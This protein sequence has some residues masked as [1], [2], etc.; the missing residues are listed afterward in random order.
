MKKKMLA[1]LPIF[2]ATATVMPFAAKSVSAVEAQA[3][4]KTERLIAPQTYEEY[5]PLTSPTDVAASENYTAIAD[6]NAIYIYDRQENEY[7]KF[8]HGEENAP[9][10]TVTKLQFDEYGTL[11]FLDSSVSTNFYALNVETGAEKKIDLA[12]GTFTVHGDDL[13]FTNAQED[14]YTLS[15]ASEALSP[16]A[17]RWNNVST[18]SFWN[19]EL[20][21]VRA[22]NYLM[23]IDPKSQA[24]PDPSK[25]TFAIFSKQINH[26]AISDGVLGC[27]NAAG[28]FV[29]YPLSQISDDDMLFKSKA[30]DFSA[31]ST[32]GNYFYT[33]ASSDATV[34]QYST[35]TNAFTDFEISASSDSDHRFSEANDVCLVGDKLFIA[36][37]GNERVSVYNRKTQSFEKAIN[38]ALSPLFLSADEKTL[39]IAS[40]EKAILYSLE[41]ATYGEQ[42]GQFSTFNGKI[43]GTAS[44]YGTYY[45]ISENNYAYTLQASEET[46]A[47]LAIETKKTSTRYPKALTADVYGNLYILSGSDVFV[48]TEATFTSPIEPGEKVCENLPTSTTKLSIDYNGTIYALAN[49]ALYRGDGTIF[50]FDDTLVYYNDPNATPILTSFAFGVEE[51][52]TYILCEGNYLVQSTA[53]SLPTVK[54]IN[55]QGAD[56]RIFENASAEFSVVKTTTN[57]LLVEFDLQTLSGA[58]HFPYVSFERANTQRTALKIGQTDSYYLLAEYDKTAGTYRTYLALISS[59]EPM[60]ADAYRTEY[61][62]EEQK[63]GYITS[64]ITLYK[65][66]YLTELLK[67]GELARGT[68][69]KVLGEIKEL[70]HAYFHV[71]YESESGEIKT[72][73]IPQAFVTDFSGLPQTSETIEVGETE[74]DDAVFRLAYL[75]LGFA[76]IC[77]LTDYLFLRKKK[78]DDD[79]E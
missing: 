8:E 3:S 62:S 63:T 32:F 26:I 47:W 59:C 38:V 49:D 72:G 74:N 69:V 54:T 68:Q 7:K 1:M 76:A 27:T 22:D 66:P 53:L 51:N 34:L 28:E 64:A 5:L 71:S 77:I 60:E 52:E 6:G 67:S 41:A 40:E 56:E 48:F 36:D 25:A 45:L 16:V 43:V 10:S 44:V 39:L 78:G 70:D 35:Q 55:V 14:L 58:E 13:Y 15:L 18:L 75:L 73:Y 46:G 12:C 31:V 11:Y 9:E 19:G 17:L 23:K 61:S 30:E 2:L 57:A 24:E 65:F 50:D 21:F 4:E 79:Y 29:A 37:N 20:Y 33:I 42:M